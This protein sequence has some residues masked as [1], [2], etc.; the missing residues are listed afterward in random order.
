MVQ[1][2]GFE[3]PAYFLGGSR[4]ILMSYACAKFFIK[5]F[6]SKGKKNLSYNLIMLL[7]CIILIFIL[8]FSYLN[9]KTIS[10]WRR[11]YLR[12]IIG[13]T[14]RGERRQDNHIPF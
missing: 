3:P 9:N 10:K 2:G 11:H 13:V 8:I 7:L 1:A 14:V 12:E 5:L 4:S 6:I